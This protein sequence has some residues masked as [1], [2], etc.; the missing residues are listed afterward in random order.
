MLENAIANPP[1]CKVE[2]VVDIVLRT[3]T[4]LMVV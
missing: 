4:E 2:Q 1:Q 3:V